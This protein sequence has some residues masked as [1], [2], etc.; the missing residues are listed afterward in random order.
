MHNSLE[1]IVP[2]CHRH[3]R[4]HNQNQTNIY[5]LSIASF[6][7]TILRWCVR[8]EKSTQYT[9]LKEIRFHF[10]KF[11]TTISLKKFNIGLKLPINR[12]LKIQEN[13]RYLCLATKKINPNKSCTIINKQKKVFHS[14]KRGNKRRSPYVYMY[15][16][17]GM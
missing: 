16:I 6:Y 17:K 14:L 8:T 1:P 5:D 7:N 13:R 15:Y 11:S 12:C 2:I 4:F 9:T 3:I 10:F